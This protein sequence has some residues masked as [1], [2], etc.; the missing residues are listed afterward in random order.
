M[1]QAAAP[2]P[3]RPKV[4][5][6]VALLALLAVLG[7][8]TAM[9]APDPFSTIDRER[10]SRFDALP[11]GD[12][13]AIKLRHARH[14]QVAIGLFGN[15]RAVMVGAFDLG[16]A[17]DRFFNFALPNQFRRDI[18]RLG[19]LARAGLRVIIYESPLIPP[20]GADVEGAKQHEAAANRQLARALCESH[21]LRCILDPPA[22]GNAMDWPDCCHP[23]A[24][25]LGAYLRSIA[26]DAFATL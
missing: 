1:D 12:I 5:V 24:A 16:L 11:L 9:L 17:P 3:F 22:I 25:A 15:S 2:P 4:V 21:G 26:A 8:P 18:G 13:A 20:S 19:A 7:L 6:V 10:M 23:P 14:S